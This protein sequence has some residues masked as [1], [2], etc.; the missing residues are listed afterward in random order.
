[1]QIVVWE[2]VPSIHTYTHGMGQHVSAGYCVHRVGLMDLGQ[3]CP[4]MGIWE[5]EKHH[6]IV[7]TVNI[8][9]LWHFYAHHPVI[10]HLISYVYVHSPKRSSVLVYR[11]YFHFCSIRKSYFGLD[12]CETPKLLLASTPQN[13]DLHLR[14]L[15]CSS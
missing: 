12:S 9:V 2:L 6:L 11:Q 15:S 7:W 8:S 13:L 4:K 1:M 5:E 14:V 10:Y 3:R